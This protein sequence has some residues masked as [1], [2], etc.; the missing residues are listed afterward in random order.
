MFHPQERL[1]TLATFPTALTQPDAGRP[2][3]TGASRKS[4]RQRR[5][6]ISQGQFGYGTRPCRG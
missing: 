3:C 4:K 2:G 6:D 1:T 5:R